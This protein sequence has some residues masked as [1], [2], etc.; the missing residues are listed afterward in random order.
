MDKEN[1]AV[2]PDNR[3]STLLVA[4]LWLDADT[5][6]N[7]NLIDYEIGG[8]GLNDP[9]QGHYVQIWTLQLVGDDVI[10]YADNWPEEILFTRTGITELSLAFD[11]NMNPFVAFVEND[12]A[13]YWWYD[14]NLGDT[15]FTSLPAGSRTPRCTLDDKRQNMTSTSDIILSYIGSND[16][17]YFRMERER[18]TVERTLKT[19]V[20][21]RIKRVGMNHYNRLQWLIQDPLPG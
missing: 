21:G 9:S 1:S 3:L 6:E 10:I 19:G 8:I 17:L 12:V 15:T 11:Q 18:Y 14:T 7:S 5:L 13:K 16:T 20:I 2:I 4:G